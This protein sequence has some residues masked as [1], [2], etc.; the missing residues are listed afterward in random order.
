VGDLTDILRFEQP[1]KISLPQILS[2]SYWRGF[3]PSKR[4]NPRERKSQVLGTRESNRRER[5]K[6]S[7]NGDER[8]SRM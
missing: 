5:Q 3:S 8:K 7:Q 6:E 1:Q 2:C 4:I